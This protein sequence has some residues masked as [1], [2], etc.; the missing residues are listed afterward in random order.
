MIVLLSVLQYAILRTS[1]WQV[2]PFLLNCIN[3]SEISRQLSISL[4]RSPVNLWWD[5]SQLS[6]RYILYIHCI[7][8]VRAIFYASDLQVKALETSWQLTRDNQFLFKFFQTQNH[9]LGGIQIYLFTVF[10]LS[11]KILGFYIPISRKALREE[12][13][14][15]VL[16]CN[17]S[18]CRLLQ[19]NNHQKLI[20]WMGFQYFKNIYPFK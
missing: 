20:I 13:K 1:Y 17:F 9:Y 7:H 2:M 12:R 5:A 18:L 14:S 11:L 6:G 19:S 4:I 16:Y 10:H 8:S 3:Y 15:K